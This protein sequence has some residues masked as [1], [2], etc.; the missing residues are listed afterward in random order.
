MGGGGGDNCG[1][2][3]SCNVLGNDSR[4]DDDDHGGGGG[5]GWWRG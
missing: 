4:D 2:D 1:A 3:T 5:D